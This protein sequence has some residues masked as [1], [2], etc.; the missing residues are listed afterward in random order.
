MFLLEKIYNF[1][2]LMVRLHMQFLIQGKEL[3]EV[4]QI[5]FKH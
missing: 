1:K 5:I 4:V 2:D 3:L